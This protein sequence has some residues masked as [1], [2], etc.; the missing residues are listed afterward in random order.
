MGAKQ[1]KEQLA[2]GRENAF[3]S[4][5]V[6]YQTLNVNPTETKIHKN[7]QQNETNEK[8]QIP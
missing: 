2:F 7:I 1:K 6:K 5:T 4:L 3:V 8:G